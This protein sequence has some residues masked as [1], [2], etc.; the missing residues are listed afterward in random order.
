MKKRI[1]QSAILI[2]ILAFGFMIYSNEK[3][4][5]TAK[6]I[7]MDE[8]HPFLKLYQKEFEDQTIICAA[9]EDVNNDGK[10]DLVVV[11]NAEG[12]EKNHSIV[13]INKDDKNYILSKTA[14]APRENV[15]VKFKNIDDKDNIEFI[16]S[17]SKDGNYGYAIYR[18]EED[19]E[20]RD[21][22]SE[23]MEDCC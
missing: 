4:I 2:I 10:K 23:D 12:D 7:G 3:K 17:G 5:Q 18:L 15:E 9:E 21:L 6:G 13:L 11:Y 8:N 16:I 19:L 1:I 20:I 22:F 14:V